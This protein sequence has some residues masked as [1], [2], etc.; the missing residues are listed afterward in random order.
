I[1]SSEITPER[2]YVRRREFLGSAGIA[3]AAAWAGV[4]DAR[5]SA[6]AAPAGTPLPV[7]K[8]VATTTDP[9]TSYDAVTTYNNFYEFGIEKSDPSRNSKNFKPRPWSVAVEGECGKPGV[10]TLEDVLKPHDLE[11]RVYR[12]RCVEGWSMVIPWVGFP[13]G[14]LLKRFQPTSNAKFVEFQTVVRP[15]EMPGQRL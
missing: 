9:S 6:A 4:L 3:L 5:P 12:H 14:D 11:E 10:Y 1:S 15:D 7:K 13:L 8:K 2:V